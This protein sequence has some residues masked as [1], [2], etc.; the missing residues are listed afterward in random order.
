MTPVVD[1]PTAVKRLLPP[2]GRDALVGLSAIWATVGALSETLTAAVSAM[3][4]A[5]R[6]M[7][8]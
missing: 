7:T 4:F 5:A 1:L 8:L 3:P 6:A 2:M